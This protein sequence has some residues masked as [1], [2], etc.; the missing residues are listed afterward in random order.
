LLRLCFRQSTQQQ[1]RHGKIH[2]SFAGLRS[3]FAIFTQPTVKVEPGQGSFHNPPPWEDLKAS[4][5]SGRFL[6]WTHPHPAKALP[7][8]PGDFYRPGQG[9]F[10][11]R[12]KTPAIGNIHPTDDRD[13]GMGTECQRATLALHP[14][15]PCRQGELWPSEQ[16]PAYP[17]EYGVC[18]LP[19][20][21][22]HP[23][24]VAPFSLVLTDWLSI[25]AAV[26]WGT[27]RFSRKVVLICSHIPCRRHCR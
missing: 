3:Q 1:A 14:G 25:M 26:G 5:V 10:H 23:S 24:R 9:S 8:V 7:P 27:R 11:P 18:G 20:A 17:P 13:T 15:Q 22:R 12:D 2:P 6:S 21:C 16:S 19:P 4:R